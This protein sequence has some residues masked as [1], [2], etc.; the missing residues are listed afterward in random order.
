MYIEAGGN[1]GD[2]EPD[3]R[4]EY[5]FP[6][7]MRAHAAVVLSISC[8]LSGEFV[9][10]GSDKLMAQHTLQG[11]ELVAASIGAALAGVLVA[12]DAWEK[13]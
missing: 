4:G 5:K 3:E 10:K 11:A 13:E 12:Y 7:W 1:P 6:W 8:A 9:V 2:S